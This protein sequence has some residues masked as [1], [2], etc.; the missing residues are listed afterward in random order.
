MAAVATRAYV[1]QSGDYYL[2]P[3]SGVQVSAATLQQLVAPAPAHTQALPTIQRESEEGSPE[4]MAV[5]YAD[6][7]QV[8]QPQNAHTLQRAAHPLTYRPLTLA[9][10]QHP[11]LHEPP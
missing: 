2:C 1:Q 6:T 7:N 9:Q 5:G 3:V 11:P 8:T 10:T 4:A